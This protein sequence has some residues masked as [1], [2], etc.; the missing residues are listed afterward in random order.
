M[1]KDP[2][3]CGKLEQ[4]LYGTRDAGANWAASYSAFLKDIGLHQGQTN[5]CHFFSSS[6][7]LK[8]IVHGDD[9]LWTGLAQELEWLRKQFEN[10]YECKVETIGFDPSGPQSARFLNRVISYTSEGISFEADQRLVEALVADLGLQN[11]TTSPTPG[12]KPPPIPKHDHQQ[13]MERRLG[14]AEG[15]DCT[16]ANL[17]AENGRLRQE[18]ARLLGRPVGEP[19]ADQEIN[20][21]ETEVE[22]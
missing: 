11:S 15:G 1:S 13:L 2:N 8:G 16:I 5:P 7:S 12:S 9:F 22:F 10:K 21:L 17:K 6:R 19:K 20:Q 18:I 4:S 3:L 14:C